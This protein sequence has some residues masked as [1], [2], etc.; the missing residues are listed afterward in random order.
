MSLANDIKKYQGDVNEGIANNKV[1]RVVAFP[2][3]RPRR[4][5]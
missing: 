5:Q 3:D 4:L 1:D 2:D